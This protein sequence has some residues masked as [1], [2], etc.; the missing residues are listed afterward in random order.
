MA[1][2]EA[3]EV[4]IQDSIAN[5]YMSSL[6]RARTEPGNRWESESDTHAFK[7][8]SLGILDEDQI[9]C[10][11]CLPLLSRR[12]YLETRHDF[13]L[14]G[15]NLGSQKF[16]AGVP[17]GSPI[18]LGVRTAGGCQMCKLFQ[19][20]SSDTLSPTKIARISAHLDL[21]FY[22]AALVSTSSAFY[23][24]LLAGFSLGYFVFSYKRYKGERSHEV[25]DRIKL[26]V[27]RQ[28]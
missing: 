2:L 6:C 27:T 10:S 17:L 20:L 19:K 9:L 25:L 12:G 23:Y 4:P 11:K 13:Q 22:A 14:P 7:S 8:V 16:R 3:D 21:T 18:E 1:L 28:R 5:I 15:F 24:A 26:H